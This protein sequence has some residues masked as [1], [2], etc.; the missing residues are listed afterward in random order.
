MEVKRREGRGQERPQSWGLN[1]RR[2]GVAHVE[3]RESGFRGELEYG[4]GSFDVHMGTSRR[5]LGGCESGL[6]GKVWKG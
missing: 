5:Q 4:V 3:K 6:D 2:G 1:P